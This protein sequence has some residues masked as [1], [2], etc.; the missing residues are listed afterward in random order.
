ISLAMLL[1][2]TVYRRWLPKASLLWVDIL[3][4]LLIAE[5]FVDLRLCQ[6]MRFRL[7]WQ[8]IQFGA[9]PKMVWRLA[10]PYLPDTVIGLILIAGLYAVFIGLWQRLTPV[11]SARIGPG[12]RF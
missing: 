4:L 12:G 5:S 7:D 2:A 9:D 3:N 11:K 8:A 6:T 10:Q 1:A